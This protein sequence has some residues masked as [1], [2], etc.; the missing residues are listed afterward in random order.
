M[1]WTQ[2][3]DNPLIG[4]DVRIEWKNKNF[5]WSAYTV[6]DCFDGWI[7]L[8]GRDEDDAPFE[9]GDIAVPMKSIEMIEVVRPAEE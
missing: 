7:L 8:R 9:G 5:D 2:G 4:R 6:L 3:S 1:N